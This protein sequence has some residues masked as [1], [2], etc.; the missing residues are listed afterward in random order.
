[1]LARTI[2][3]AAWARLSRFGRDRRGGLAIQAAFLGLPMTVMV[4]GTIDIANG[5][6]AKTRLQDALDAAAL[7]AARSSA[8]TDAGLQEIGSSS[9]TANMTGSTATVTSSSFTADGNKVIASAKAKVVPA[10]ANLWLQGDIIV[11]ARS[12]ITRSVNKIELAL[13]LD[14]TGSM[15]G[16]K[17]SNLKTASTNLID[18]LSEAAA[19]SSEPDAVKIAIAPFSMTVKVGA[20]Y[21]NASWMDQTGAAPIND[22]IFSSHA[23]RFT[24]L[25][26]MGVAWGGCVESRAS[27]YNVQDTAP[28]ASTPATLFTPFFAP[29]EPSSSGYYNSYLPDL[30]TSSNWKTRQGYVLKYNQ[31]PTVTGTNSSTGYDY[32]PNAGCQLSPV[33]RL[34]SNWSVLKSAVG[35]MNA[36]GDTNIPMGLMWGWHL[37]SPNAPFADGRAYGTPKSTKIVVLMTDGENTMTSTGN[38]NAS[39]YN[40]LG[41]IWQGRLGITS[42]AKS[43]RTSAMDDR[44]S[45][46][47]S[48]MKAQGIVIYT[49]RVEVSSGDSSLLRNCA[50]SSDKFYDV[51]SASQLDSVFNAIA[52]S[53]ENLRILK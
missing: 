28:S 18:T 49:V 51:Q 34:T 17:L 50:T 10:V 38:N 20:D 27:P 36:V 31:A 16:S 48:N 47:C 12:E 19:R 21:R 43:Q 3:R 13:V 40:S 7:T 1:M 30:T 9:L 44:L 24:L 15:K 41:Y 4:I 42:G 46:L 32:G 29:D 33:T 22:E 26:Q 45:T 8:F 6:A 14:N 53:I 37:L 35:D 52:G 2:L 25:D 23:N 39:L 11:G 5:S